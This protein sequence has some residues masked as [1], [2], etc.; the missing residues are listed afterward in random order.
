MLRLSFEKKGQNISISRKEYLLTW[1]HKFL[2]NNQYY[3]EV[4]PCSKNTYNKDYFSN[5]EDFISMKKFLNDSRKHLNNNNLEIEEGIP[6]GYAKKL[7]VFIDQNRLPKIRK[8]VFSSINTKKRK[9]RR[10][11]RIN[12]TSYSSCDRRNKKIYKEIY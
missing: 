4:L 5:K 3:Y 1:V 9:K 11:F 6:Y 8:I 12:S 2:K 10:I 7:P